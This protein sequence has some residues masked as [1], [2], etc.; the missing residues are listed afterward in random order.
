MRRF[1]YGKLLTEDWIPQM[2]VFWRRAAGGAVGPFRKDLC[3]AMDYDFW[4]RLG[5]RWPGRHVDQYL[6]AFRWYG[7]SKS[8]SGYLEATREAF[9]VAVENA[10]GQYPWA[11]WWHKV[12]RIKTISIYRLLDALGGRKSGASTRPA[13]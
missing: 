2:G 4:L 5:A 3:Y 1:D 7:S 8:G 12:H 10:R 11:I 6:A 9:Q 13:L